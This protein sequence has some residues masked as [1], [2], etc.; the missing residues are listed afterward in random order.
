VA[1]TGCTVIVLPEPNV[2]TAEF[3][4]AAPGSREAALLEPGM[5]VES[6]QAV[7]LT[8]GSAFGLAAADGVM[9]ALEAEGR[10]HPA[11]MGPVPIVPAAVVYDLMTGDGTVR[12]GPADGAAAYR[13]ATSEPVEQGRVGAGTGTLVAGWRGIEAVG[14]GGLGSALVRREGFMVGALAVVNAVGDVF[15]LEGEALTGGALVP[16]PPQAPP[17]PLERTTLVMVATDAAMTRIKLR[18]MAVRGHDALAVCVRPVHTSHDGDVVFAAS[19][20]RAEADPDVV[21]EA[22]WEAT[23]RAL[24]A[25]IRASRP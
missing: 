11:L 18:R 24:E 6:A 20:G 13:D 12:P 7:L 19:C 15:T 5:S 3:R 22:G 23:G 8:G 25:A 10:G 4:G 1:Q 17:S 16:G 21:A 2:V 14:P 9:A